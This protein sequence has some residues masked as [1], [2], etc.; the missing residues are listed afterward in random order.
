MLGLIPRPVVGGLGVRIK[1]LATLL[2]HVGFVHLAKVYA[3]PI[4]FL[5][6]PSGQY[7][8]DNQQ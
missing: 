7:E 3:T 5:H 1:C 8:L 6:P 4:R 2:R